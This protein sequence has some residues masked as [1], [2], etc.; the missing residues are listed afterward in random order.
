MSP[1]PA[2]AV[3]HVSCQPAVEPIQLARGK[4]GTCGARPAQYLFID[5]SS[6]DQPGFEGG[7]YIYASSAAK[8]P[9]HLW[10]ALQSDALSAVSTDHCPFNWPEQ[11]GIN[12][13]EF[14]VVP[15][16]ARG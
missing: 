11:K 9:K 6:L 15:N 16:G 2:L 8:A 3:V 1:A 13:Q 7:K 5:E 4:A 12:G 10:K 14:Q